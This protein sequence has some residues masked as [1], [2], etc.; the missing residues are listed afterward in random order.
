M[1]FRPPRV[2]SVDDTAVHPYLGQ[3]M[4]CVVLCV[5]YGFILPQAPHEPWD[6]LGSLYYTKT[7]QHDGRD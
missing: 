3:K 5:A 7:M 1:P 2:C 4:Y 6:L